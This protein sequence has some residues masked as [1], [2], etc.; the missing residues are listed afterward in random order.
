MVEYGTRESKVFSDI[1]L[2]LVVANSDELELF[3]EKLLENEELVSMLKGGNVIIINRKTYPHLQ[4]VDQFNLQIMDGNLPAIIENDVYQNYLRDLISILDWVPER[5]G[6][7]DYMLANQEQEIEKI[8]GVLY[9]LGHSFNYAARSVDPKYKKVQNDIKQIRRKLEISDEPIDKELWTAYSDI[10]SVSIGLV[11][12]VLR[13]VYSKFDR[14]VLNDSGGAFEYYDG[15]LIRING[16]YKNFNL[17]LKFHLLRYQKMLELAGS[18]LD[19]I[20]YH[21]SSDIL[22]AQLPIDDLMRHKLKF[23]LDLDVEKLQQLK[24]FSPLRFGYILRA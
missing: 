15:S 5:V 19:L 6:R 1:D 12:Y 7:L 18:N 11:N 2:M 16:G 17:A 20:S 23:L 10:R 21:G 22:E 14:H 3:H 24:L 13:Q 8:V 4:K 9:S